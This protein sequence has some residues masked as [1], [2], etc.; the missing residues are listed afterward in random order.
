MA[1]PKKIQK[2]PT[3]KINSFTER[4]LNEEI[5]ENTIIGIKDYTRYTLQNGFGDKVECFKV[6]GENGDDYLVSLSFINTIGYCDA[7]QYKRTPYPSL[8]LGEMLID[9]V[10]G[11]LDDGYA[12]VPIVKEYAN[13]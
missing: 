1:L 2:K 12:W 10:E 11:P 13:V 3:H 4:P 5:E 7:I 6:R 8:Y 9:P